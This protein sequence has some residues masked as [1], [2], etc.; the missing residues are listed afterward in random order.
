MSRISPWGLMIRTGSSPFACTSLVPAA[1]QQ[2][3]PKA[4]TVFKAATKSAL[5]Y[6]PQT[7]VKA[8]KPIQSPADEPLIACSHVSYHE[9]RITRRKSIG[10]DDRTNRHVGPSEAETIRS[11][12]AEAN[13]RRE[14][15]RNPMSAAE[16]ARGKDH[17]FDQAAKV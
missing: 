16:R 17:S 3:K 15:M 7:G 12:A 13:L 10:A 8:Q 11:P 1:L 5:R 9:G 4:G 2:A 14:S 6:G